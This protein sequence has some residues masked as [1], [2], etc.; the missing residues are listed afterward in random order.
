YGVDEP[1]LIDVYRRLWDGVE[2][3]R[4]EYPL[5][6]S[7]FLQAHPFRNGMTE[8]DPSLLDGIEVF[9]MHPEHLSRN[10]VACR[11]AAEKGLGILAAGSDFHHPAARGYSTAAIRTREMPR[12]SFELAEILKNKDYLME[13]G[14]RVAAFP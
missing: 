4:K 5:P 2:R 10:A 14:G 8:V 6:K 11:Y 13:I 9:N 7:V 12:D 3:F 1:M